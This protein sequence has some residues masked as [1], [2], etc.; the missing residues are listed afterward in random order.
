MLNNFAYLVF[1]IHRIAPPRRTRRSGYTF[2][3]KFAIISPKAATWW[4]AHCSVTESN[5]M[6]GVTMG[7]SKAAR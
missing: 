2:M 1:S 6:V 5:M 7:K 4:L 3:P